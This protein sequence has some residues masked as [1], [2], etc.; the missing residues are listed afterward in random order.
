MDIGHLVSVKAELQRAADAGAMAGARALWPTAL[1][2][3]LNPPSTP[4]CTSARSVALHDVAEIRRRDALKRENLTIEVGQYDYA[5]KAFTPKRTAPSPATRCG[6]RPAGISTISFSPASGT[7]P[8]CSPGSRPPPPW[9]SPRRWAKATIPIAI[10]K[11]YV[12]PG[13]TININFN[14]DPLDNGGWFAD[15]DIRPAPPPS[16]T[17]LSTTPVLPCRSA[18]SSTCKTGWTPP[19]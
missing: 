13:T 1:P 17:I 15:C 8:G 14:P 10:N 3:V 4:D 12:V 16:R 2:M 6:C 5:T 18:T 9:G 7:S 11:I 19:P